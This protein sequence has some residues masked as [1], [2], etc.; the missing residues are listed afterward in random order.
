MSHPALPYRP[1]TGVMLLNAGNDVFVG[2]RI[3]TTQEAWQMPQGGIDEGEGIEESAFR[4]LEEEIGTGNAK[5]LARTK[6]WLTYDLPESLIPKVWGGRYRGQKQVWF[7]MRF[8]GSDSDIDINTEHPEFRDWK[9]VP[10]EKLPKMIVPFK[11]PLYE[12][13]LKEFL[14]YLKKI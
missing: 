3:D 14:P 7:L 10:M 9:W 2:K 4:E 6:G 8:L 5:V 12:R 1:G 13:L 11:R